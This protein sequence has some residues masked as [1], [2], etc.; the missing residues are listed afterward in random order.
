MMTCSV[1]KKTK[2]QIL[3]VLLKVLVEGS[4]FCVPAYFVADLRGMD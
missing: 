4:A 3:Y 2:A 1:C